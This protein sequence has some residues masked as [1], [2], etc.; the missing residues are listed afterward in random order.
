MWLQP[1]LKCLIFPPRFLNKNNIS[2]PNIGKLIL[3]CLPIHEFM[4]CIVLVI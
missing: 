1:Q 2:V 4:R 3:N